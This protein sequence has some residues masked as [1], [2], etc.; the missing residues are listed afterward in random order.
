MIGALPESLINF[1]GE[2]LKQL[3]KEGHE[4][5]AMAS[6]ATPEVIGQLASMGVGYR[7]YPVQ[8]NGMNPVKDVQTYLALRHALRELKP[9]IVFSYTIKPVI[10][11]GIALKG[12][13][14][15]RFYA[16][17]TGLGFAFLNGGIVRKLLTAMVVRLYRVALSGASRVIFQNPDDRDLFIDRRIVDEVKC[18]LVNGSGVDLDRFS[19]VPLPRDGT[20]FIAIGRL[21][22]GKGFREYAQA[23]QWVKDHY[24]AAVFR[25]VGPMDPSPD[26]I[27][28]EEVKGW[29]ARG[30]IEYMGATEDSRPFL[31][32]CHVFV[33]PSYQEG[34]PRTV[35]EAMA[36]GRPILTTDVPGCRE[37][38]IPGE[39][40]YLIPKANPT[41]LGER[42]VWFIE[43]RDEWARMGTRSRS[44]AEERFDV[45][46]VNRA[47]MTLLELT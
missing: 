15:S 22:G 40:G 43:H 26:G 4:V 6:E 18:A 46:S 41:A 9:D 7:S 3:A 39:N 8:R 33:L 29:E 23:A 17:I 42:M 12:V 10:W 13:S 28:M 19:F 1:R 45:H 44:L 2:L 47:L 11:S 32:S 37:T 5:T 36:T 30:W 21:L 34:M 25:L 35:L 38:V 20:V 14:T 16:L 27:P 24:P 31:A